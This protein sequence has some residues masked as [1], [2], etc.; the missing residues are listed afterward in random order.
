MRIL[1]TGASGFVGRHLS[2][3]L[4]SQKGA[5]IYGLV[6]VGSKHTLIA[7][8]LPVRAELFS[9][10][11][12]LRALRKI[13]PDRIYHLAAQSSV[14]QSWKEPKKTFDIN[15]GGTRNLLEAARMACPKA[16]ILIAC[17]A[18]EYGASGRLFPKLSE[19]APLKPLNPY[20][21][22]K[23]VQDLLGKH[24][25]LM[26]GMP[27]IRMRAFNHS[28]PGQEAKF[29][30]PSFAEQVADISAGR[31]KPE[32]KVGNLRAIRDFSDV[33]DVVRA[34]YLALEKGNPGEA[35]NV[36]S[37]RGRRVADV[38]KYYLNASSVRIRV[39]R[40]H[41]RLRTS[42]MPRLV[43]DA[44][45]LIRDTGWRPRIRFETTLRDV[46]NDKKGLKS[47]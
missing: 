18:D 32:I 26:Y 1:I 44:R 12:M 34:Y 14:A 23:L 28:G 43:G 25:F 17:S 38:L 9:K 22:S 46:L 4:L 30:V 37:G 41:A 5:K 40:D 16:R 15:V 20:G 2:T 3:F 7:G 6:R 47:G 24:Y 35:Y 29:A 11:S 19:E 42:D 39:R 21:V 27:I 33:R 13:R 8:V 10:P 45:K 36:A 31:Q